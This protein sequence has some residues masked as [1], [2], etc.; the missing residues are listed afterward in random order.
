MDITYDVVIIGGGAVGSATAYFLMQEPGFSGSVAVVEKDPSYRTASSALS[1][2]GIRQ[3]YSSEVNIRIG[4]FGIGFMRAA[5]TTLA[6]DGEAPTLGLREQGYLFLAS[7]DGV[8]H[9]HANHALQRSLGVEVEL[10]EGDD[11]LRRF[12]WLRRTCLAAGSFGRNEGWLDGYSLLQ[13]FRRKARSL[14][15]VY[16]QD[17]AVGLDHAGARITAVRLASGALL[18]CDTVVNAAGPRSRAIAEM[19][20]LSLPVEARKRC[21]FVIACK[22]PIAGCPLVIDP[23][24]VWFRPEGE[25]FLSGV[26][27]PQ[28][29]DPEDFGLEIDHQIFDDDVWPVLAQRVPAFEAVKVVN[30]WAGHYEY[31]TFDQNGIIGRHPERPNLIFATGFSGHGLQQSPATGRGVSELIAFGGYRTLDLRPLSVERIVAGRPLLER[32]I[33]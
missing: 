21:V 15:A 8:G 33:V 32:N 17:E 6:V 31:N 7:P 11:L 28:E 9:L 13:A 20:G 19:A 2:G 29:R 22:T 14:G 24:G 10:L 5:G 18:V 30:T 3:Q 16:L 23:S 1:A 26:S 12:P 27:P 25:Y 4:Q